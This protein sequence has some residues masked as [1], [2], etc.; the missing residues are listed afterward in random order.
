MTEYVQNFHQ[1]A[2]DLTCIFQGLSLTKNAQCHQENVN[3]II[4]K[5]SK[6]WIGYVLNIEANSHKIALR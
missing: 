5:S 1:S 6:G 3:T 4:Q 2:K